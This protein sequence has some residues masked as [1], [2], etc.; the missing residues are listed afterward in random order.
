[1]IG[2][3]LLAN[4]ALAMEYREGIVLP[5]EELYAKVNV[6]HNRLFYHY[7]SYLQGGT[8]LLSKIKPYWEYLLP[9]MD[10]KLKKAILKASHVDKYLEAVGIALMSKNIL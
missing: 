1:M 2:R 3:G 7:E 10:K 8:Q 9:D 4:P 6:F 5:R